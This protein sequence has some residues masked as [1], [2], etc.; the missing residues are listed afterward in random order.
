MPLDVGNESLFPLGFQRRQVVRHVA[1]QQHVT[2]RPPDEVARVSRAVSR[3]RQRDD[4]AVRR[5]WPTPGEPEH[6]RITPPVVLGEPP[7]STRTRSVAVSMIH[8][9][10][11]SGSVKP[12]S[13]AMPRISPNGPPCA[14]LPSRKVGLSCNVPVEKPMMRMGTWYRWSLR[15]RTTKRNAQVKRG[16]LEAGYLGRSRR[17]RD[18]PCAFN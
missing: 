13:R 14:G 7:V 15:L 4:R 8:D 17:R 5:D 3:R 6:C 2:L 11:G 10:I 9:H 16:H 12:G 18:A 1:G